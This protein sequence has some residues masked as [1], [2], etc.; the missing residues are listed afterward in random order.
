MTKKKILSLLL[1]MFLFLGV[2]ACV[3]HADKSVY[4]ESQENRNIE[5]TENEAETYALVANL[6]LSISGGNGEVSAVV[7]NTFT[8]FSGTV[9]V[10][11][12]LYF[13]QDYTEDY[14]AMNERAS[15]YIYDLDQGKSISAT[16]VTGNVAGYWIGRMRYKVDGRSW[17]E[18]VTG[19]YQC[20]ADGNI[21]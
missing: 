18:R 21:L 5:Q 14:H 9:Q 3:L 7:K 6:R 16:T 1:V 19:V 17:E 4:A 15:N 11:V 20:D 13:S 2:M 12:Y 10:Y 8:L